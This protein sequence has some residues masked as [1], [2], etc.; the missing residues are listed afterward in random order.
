[1]KIGI[2]TFH[3]AINFGAVLQ[4]YALYRSLSDMGHTVEV[5]DYRPAYIEKYRKPFYWNDFKKQGLLRKLKTLLS[6]PLV[7]WKKRTSAKVFDTFINQNLKTSKVVKKVQDIPY[8]DIIFFGSDQIWSPRICEGI[9][10]MYYG[11]LPKGKTKIVS[12]AASLGTP[13]VLLQQ[14]G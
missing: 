14:S 12:Y 9:D 5:I 11:Q 8:F 3:R 1:M 4:C 7:Y 2:L 6:I 13:Q 10:P